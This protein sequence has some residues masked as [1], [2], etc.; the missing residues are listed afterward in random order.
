L[1][2]SRGTRLGVYEITAPIG[3]GGMVYRAAGGMGPVRN[4]HLDRT[5]WEAE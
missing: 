3:E 5:T 2:V 4:T 1:G